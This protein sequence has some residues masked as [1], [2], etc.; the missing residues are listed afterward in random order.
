MKAVSLKAPQQVEL[1][2]IPVPTI[3]DDQLLIRMGASTICTSDLNDIRANPFDIPLPVII[4]HEAAGTV[5]EVG[6]AVE[7]FHIG[8]RITAHPVHH[9]GECVACLDGMQHLCL[10]MAHF[11][12]NLQG[13]M[14]EY[15]YVR[16]DRTRH[17]PDTMPFPLAALA[18]PVCVCLEALAQARLKAG[19]RLLIMGDGPFGTLMARLARTMDLAQ[20]VVAG[21]QD[22]RLSF[23]QPA[24]TVNTQHL[25]DP[26]ARLMQQQDGAGYDAVILAVG[27]ADAFRQGLECLK[28]KG[29]LVVFSAIPE[30]TGVDLVSVHIKELEIVGACNDEDRFD[31]AVKMLADPALG[32]ADLVTH[33]F[34]LD[35]FAQALDLAANAHDQVMKIALMGP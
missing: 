32:I 16:A 31:D 34:P 18:E 35:Q 15:F 5:V 11:G 33:R 22:F 14:A 7:G 21:W 4:G 23:S 6:S 29:R 17:I 10:N 28:P 2:D 3:G 24:Q 27:S 26:V 13:T 19:Q 12:I 25:C 30:A 1:V 8:D 20:V 9:C